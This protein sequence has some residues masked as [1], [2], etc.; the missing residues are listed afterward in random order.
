[1]TSKPYLLKSP[2]SPTDVEN[3]DHMLAEL[4]TRILI[5]EKARTTI[6]QELTRTVVG[7]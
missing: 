6:A 1:M 3:L 2:L 5:L 7:Q 4:Y